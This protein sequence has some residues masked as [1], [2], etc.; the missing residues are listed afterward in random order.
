MAIITTMLIF[1]FFHEIM[2]NSYGSTYG[3]AARPESHSAW[4]DTGRQPSL[5]QILKVTA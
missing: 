2:K 1:I 3:R 4:P 5:N